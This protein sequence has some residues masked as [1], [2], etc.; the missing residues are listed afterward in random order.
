[1]VAVLDPELV[2]LAGGVG[3]IPGF[4]GPVRR[5][6]AARLSSPPRI[7]TTALGERGVVLG[8]LEAAQSA[9]SGPRI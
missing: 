6:V 4:L 7:E 9:K 8:A 1:M 3:A 2:V 5:A